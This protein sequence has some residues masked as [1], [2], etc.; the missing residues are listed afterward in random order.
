MVVQ[1]LADTQCGFKF[2]DGDVA[3]AAARGLRIDGFAFDVE[4]LRALSN[5]GLLL[6]EIPVTWTDRDGSTLRIIDGARAAMD[7]VRLAYR[8]AA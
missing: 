1:G 7:V 3:R 4:L 2:F 8:N 6:K 5:M